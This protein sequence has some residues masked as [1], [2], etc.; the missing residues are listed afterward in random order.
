MILA[1]VGTCLSSRNDKEGGSFPMIVVSI[2]IYIY[3]TYDMID[4]RHCLAVGRWP[5]AVGPQ[6]RNRKADGDWQRRSINI[7]NYLLISKRRFAISKEP[8]FMRHGVS[9]RVCCAGGGLM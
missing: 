5:L 6:M 3:D 9:D 8:R 1:T 2:R 7:I 4:D